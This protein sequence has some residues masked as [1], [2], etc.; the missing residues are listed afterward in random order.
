MNSPYFTILVGAERLELP[1]PKESI[2]SAPQ[3]PL[4]DTPNLVFSLPLNNHIASPM[5]L[6]DAYQLL[7]GVI[8]ILSG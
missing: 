6:S 8:T 3:L 1:N 4:C 7:V 5:L 2:Y